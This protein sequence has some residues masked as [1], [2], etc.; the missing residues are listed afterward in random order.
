[1]SLYPVLPPFLSLF[2]PIKTHFQGLSPDQIPDQK[3]FL[4]LSI[5]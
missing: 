2:R 1:M 5:P 4:K 3:L